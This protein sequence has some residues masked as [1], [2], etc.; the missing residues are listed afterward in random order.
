MAVYSPTEKASS[1]Q[2]IIEATHALLAASLVLCQTDATEV[3]GVIWACF[4]I[5]NTP[6]VGA[7]CLL[8]KL[9]CQ[10]LRLELRRRYPQTCHATAVFGILQAN[11]DKCSAS[12]QQALCGALPILTTWDT[13]SF[14]EDHRIGVIVGFMTDLPL[15]LRPDAMKGLG[16]L[17]SVVLDR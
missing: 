14:V 13:P 3:E 5:E 10:K 9:M 7:V 16:Q 12:A 2:S 1:C 4:I 8:T 11:F 6:M 17:A 15:A